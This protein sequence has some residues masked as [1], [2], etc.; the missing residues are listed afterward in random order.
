MQI[1][2]L[3]KQALDNEFID[4]QALILFLTIE[5]QVVSMEDDTESLDLY[6]QKNHSERMNK[7]LIE[8][9]KRMNMKCIKPLFQVLTEQGYTL[10][11]ATSKTDALFKTNGSEAEMIV[12]D[13]IYIGNE[14]YKT[15]NLLE[16][17]K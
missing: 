4:L 6:F 14:K 8:Y 15:K 1:K 11:R 16:E 9:K 5:K 10:T 3:F 7:E 17:M 2:Q 13:Y 12:D